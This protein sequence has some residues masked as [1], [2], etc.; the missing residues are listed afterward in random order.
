[1]QNGLVY[2]ACP[3]FPGRSVVRQVR[4]EAARMYSMWTF[5]RSLLSMRDTVFS[6]VV[7]VAKLGNHEQRLR[8]IA[9][10]TY[11]FVI[12][13]GRNERY[14]VLWWSA[15]SHP[16]TTRNV[17]KRFRWS[18]VISEFDYS[19]FCLAHASWVDHRHCG[20]SRLKMSQ[21]RSP[22]SFPCAPSSRRLWLSRR[23][24]ILNIL[25]ASF[26]WL[27]CKREVEFLIRDSIICHIT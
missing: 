13:D 14:C 23:S 12:A 17:L 2:V 11:L 21:E 4:N 15:G 5:C 7:P 18:K 22:F 9:N 20:H 24:F 27:A 19:R 1:M 10:N 8:S 16:V 6:I 3:P 26:Y 25:F